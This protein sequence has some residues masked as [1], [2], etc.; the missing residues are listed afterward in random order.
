[1]E[2]EEQEE[3]RKE[4]EHFAYVEVKEFRIFD[5][6]REAWELLEQLQKNLDATWYD[7]YEEL[8]NYVK[9]KGEAKVPRRYV[10]ANELRLGKWLQ[11][12]KQLYRTGKL[13]EDRCALLVE[14]CGSMEYTNKI[15]FE[16]WTELLLKYKEENGNILVRYPYVTEV[17]EHLGEWCG[18]IRRRYHVGKLSEDVIRRLE[19]VGSAGMCCRKA[20]KPNT[21]MPRLIMKKMEIW[22]RKNGTEVRTDTLLDSGW[23][24]NVESKEER[25]EREDNDHRRNFED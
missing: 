1:M 15:Q 9:E 25:K 3:L 2:F 17:G 24:L 12:Q 6:V 4:Y 20:G 8:K 10:A 23:Y 13:E 11:R 18:Y 7:Y 14:L 5:E 22:K 21:N 19:E 16:H